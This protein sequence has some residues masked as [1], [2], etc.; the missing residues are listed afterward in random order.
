MTTCA[1][2]AGMIPMA[3]GWGEGGEQSAPL[4]RAVIGGLVAAT[5]ATLL[6]LPTVFAVVQSR[7][8]G[9]PSRSTR[10]TRRASSSC[11]GPGRAGS[12]GRP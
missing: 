1:M 9:G 11:P 7:A 4:A 12:S 6:V 8:P 5:L 10:S 2:T 3:L